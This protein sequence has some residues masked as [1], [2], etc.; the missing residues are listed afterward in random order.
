MKKF[1]ILGLIFAFFCFSFFCIAEEQDLS[2]LTDIELNDLRLK[3]EEEIAERDQFLASFYSQDVPYMVGQ[4]LDAGTYL[5][6]CVKKY[7]AALTGS[8]ISIWNNLDEYDA[9]QDNPLL[10]EFIILDQSIRITLENG[11]VFFIEGGIMSFDR[12]D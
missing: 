4:D 7:I 12:I 10:Q 1:C 11:N 9:N 6:S 2:S 5:V 8:R 3:V